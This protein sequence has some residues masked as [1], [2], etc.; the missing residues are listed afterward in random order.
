MITT[1][2]NA[3]KHLKNKINEDT[4]DIKKAGRNQSTN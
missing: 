3:E 2:K 4:D 1:V